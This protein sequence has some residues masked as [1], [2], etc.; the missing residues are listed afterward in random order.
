MTPQLL[1]Q[2]DQNQKPL[3][4]P[5][6]PSL[7]KPEHEKYAQRLMSNFLN[8]LNAVWESV[9]STVLPLTRV[10][11]KSKW[12]SRSMNI[13]LGF[14]ISTGMILARMLDKVPKGQEECQTDFLGDK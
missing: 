6:K 13:V 9:C 14:V 12:K 4:F 7:L 10:I 8:L 11:I 5:A 3:Q 1:V 2:K